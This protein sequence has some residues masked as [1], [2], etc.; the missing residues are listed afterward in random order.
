MHQENI[1]SQ[2]APNKS[3]GRPKSRWKDDVEKDLRKLGI[4]N[5]RQVAQDRDG[6]RI[7]TY[8]FWIVAPH[9]N[10]K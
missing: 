6:W 7:V 3:K 1:P 8:H 9:N 5:W 4:V 10:N 2:C